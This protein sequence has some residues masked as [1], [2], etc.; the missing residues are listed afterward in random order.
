[1]GFQTLAR[2]RDERAHVVFSRRKGRMVEE[3]QLTNSES[4]EAMS[5]SSRLR[6]FDSS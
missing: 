3:C 4:L 5:E 2:G 6:V 1:M